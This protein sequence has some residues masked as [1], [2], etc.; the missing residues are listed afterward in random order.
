MFREWNVNCPRCNFM[1]AE[2]SSW[3]DKHESLR[4]Y[5]C[6]YHWIHRNMRLV[7]DGVT[8]FIKDKLG[9]LILERV[10]MQPYGV[11]YICKDYYD[12]DDPPVFF[13]SRSIDNEDITFFNKELQRDDAHP[14]KSYIREYENGSVK[15]IAGNQYYQVGPIGSN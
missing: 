2:Y 6:G 1:Y 5:E 15:T 7:V 4:C 9:E 8:V 3:G 13:H 11:T 10:E 12:D 14:E